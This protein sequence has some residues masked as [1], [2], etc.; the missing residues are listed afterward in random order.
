MIVWE[1]FEEMVAVTTVD[2]LRVTL[3]LL[4][5]T[6]GTYENEAATAFVI[7]GTLLTIHSCI[8]AAV[9]LYYK[10]RPPLPNVA[11][12]KP[13]EGTVSAEFENPVGKV[14]HITNP[15]LKRAVT[16]FGSVKM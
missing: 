16:L 12:V 5:L 11:N 15:K 9:W 10:L 1:G 13:F 3:T 2:I 14:F 4:F 6:K 8:S 7:S